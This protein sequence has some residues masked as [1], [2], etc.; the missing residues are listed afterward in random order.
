MLLYF[1]QDGGAILNSGGTVV[2]KGSEFIDN[3][4]FVSDGLLCT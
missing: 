4:A 2:I 3:R 1:W